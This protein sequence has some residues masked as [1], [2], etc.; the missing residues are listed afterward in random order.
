[1]RDWPGVLLT[2]TLWAYWVG[3]GI[4]IVRVRRATHR[5]GGLVPEQRLEQTMW[6]VWVPLVAAWLTL[7]YLALVRSNPPLA[8]PVF[9]WLV[10]GYQTLRWIAA[11]GGVI[12]LLLTSLCWSKM[13]TR[14]RMDVSLEGK[15]EL[16]TDGLFKY[17]RHPI[18]ALSLLLMACSI[19]VV[20]TVPMFFVGAVH[21][22]LNQLKARNEERHLLAV[23]GDAYRRYLARTGRFFPWRAIL[24]AD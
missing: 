10:P 4:M 3:I 17:V 13:G 14:W 8:I 11:S 2:A 9:V 1:M 23:H 21:L 18:Y 5:F 7:P 24:R 20:P 15:E 16:I 19:V 6:L 22:V 12:C